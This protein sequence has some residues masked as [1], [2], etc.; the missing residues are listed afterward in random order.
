[1]EETSAALEIATAEQ[2]VD[3]AADVTADDN[4][5]GKVVK[6]TAD[7]D[8]SDIEWQPIGGDSV[9]FAGEFDGN[10]KTISNLTNTEDV[11]RKGLFGLVEKAYI[12]DLTLKNVKFVCVSVR[13]QPIYSIGMWSRMLRSM[14]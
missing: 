8:F 11:A 13:L 4:F 5:A 10:G 6:L 1:M 3:F 12:H 7:I 14:D 2:L 9:Y